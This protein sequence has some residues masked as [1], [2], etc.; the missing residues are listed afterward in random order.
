VSS[1][2]NFAAK[3]YQKICK[4]NT[5]NPL[6]HTP[7]EPAKEAH[8]SMENKEEIKKKRRSPM[9]GMSKNAIFIHHP[10]MFP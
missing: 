8:R 9:T 3:K 4:K 10:L 6:Y 1:F 7:K 5:K 2:K